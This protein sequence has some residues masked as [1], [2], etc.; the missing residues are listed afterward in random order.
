VVAVFGGTTFAAARVMDSGPDVAAIHAKRAKQNAAAERKERKVRKARRPAAAAVPMSA[1]RRARRWAA[2]ANALCDRTYDDMLAL[3]ERS[4]AAT[5]QGLLRLYDA[6]LGRSGRFI[7]RLER[8]GPAPNRQVH[9]QLIRELKSGQAA[10]ERAVQA[11]KSQWSLSVLER[12][13][14]DSV[15]RSEGLRR[16]AEQLDAVACSQLFDP[17]TYGF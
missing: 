9:A 1:E 12:W 11:L 14:Q 7:V 5:P 16:L 13:L 4:P 6:V 2:K 17:L 15:R 10:D 3:V 8:L